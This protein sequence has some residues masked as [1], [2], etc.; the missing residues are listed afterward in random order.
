MDCVFH[1]VVS[2]QRNSYWKIRGI[3]FYLRTYIL[4]K[5]D[6]QHQ[7]KMCSY[8]PRPDS[9]K[10]QFKYAPKH[11]AVRVLSSFTIS[12]KRA[13]RSEGPFPLQQIRAPCHLFQSA[14]CETKSSSAPIFYYKSPR[15][16]CSSPSKCFL[17]G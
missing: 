13:Q 3:I 15:H 11:N 16:L 12:C 8:C 1:D 2:A 10:R 5:L 6:V 7:K 14:V 17:S 4:E 9:N